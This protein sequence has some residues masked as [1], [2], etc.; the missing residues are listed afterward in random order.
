V[1]LLWKAETNSVKIRCS[2]G[3]KKHI[4]FLLLLLYEMREKDGIEGF[5]WEN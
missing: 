5:F 4:L 2:I 3:V 1:R